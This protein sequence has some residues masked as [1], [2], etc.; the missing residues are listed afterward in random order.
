VDK[1]DFEIFGLRVRFKLKDEA[2][3]LVL[4]EKLDEPRDRWHFTVPLSPLRKGPDVGSYRPH[5]SRG[6]RAKERQALDSATLAPFPVTG[7][8]W[9]GA[10][11]LEADDIPRIVERLRS[12]QAELDALTHYDEY[13]YEDELIRE[14][15]VAVY[16]PDEEVLAELQRDA[17]ERFE[18]ERRVTIDDT[19]LAEV[20]A[21]IAHSE[22]WKPAEKLDVLAPG[23]REDPI[24]VRFR[25]SCGGELETSIYRRDD[26]CWVER[27]YCCPGDPE[28]RSRVIDR[29]LGPEVRESFSTIMALLGF[30]AE[31]GEACEEMTEGHRDEGPRS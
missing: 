26:G 28:E 21:A 6:R 17:Q 31:E 24:T 23:S 9:P 2:N 12:M 14:L 3:R 4:I 8:E 10:L 1:F 30:S 13:V 20:T 5:L 15:V 11:K 25:S 18:R 19:T 7:I 27:R 16:D 29:H 22:P